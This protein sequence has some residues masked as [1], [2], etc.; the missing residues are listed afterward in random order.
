MA[1]K[2]KRILSLK[3]N[4]L[5]AFPKGLPPGEVLGPW[6]GQGQTQRGPECLASV[7]PSVSWSG[8]SYF[9]L[10]PS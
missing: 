9:N 4:W 3:G 7:G 2:K 6:C 10:A 5:Q 8:S 1:G